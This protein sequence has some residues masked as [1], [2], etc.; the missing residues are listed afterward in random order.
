MQ[1]FTPPPGHQDDLLWRHLRA[2][3]D[4]VDQE[5]IESV[6]PCLRWMHLAGG[7]TLMR[8]GEPGDALYLLVS[9]RLRVYI[10]EG[11][12]R[13]IV[14]EIPRGEVVG[15]MSLISDAPRSATVVAIRDSVL[16]SL[17][18]EAFARL[19]SSLRR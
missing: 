15:E 18:K 6:R 10:E 9:G 11:D 16:V 8:Q 7:Q 2:F 1:E 13:R 5:A 19:R 3:L 12:Q 14:R 4:S 17:D